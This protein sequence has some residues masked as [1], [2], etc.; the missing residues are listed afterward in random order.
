MEIIKF[1]KKGCG[2]CIRVE[3]HLEDSGVKFTSVDVEQN[4]EEAAK[5]DVFFT[6]P[7]TVLKD[8]DKEIMRTTGFNEGQLEEIIER[9]QEVQ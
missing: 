9:Y 6:V 3:G 2:P 4:P 8:G 5:H 1:G 7:V